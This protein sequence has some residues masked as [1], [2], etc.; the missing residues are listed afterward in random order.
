MRKIVLEKL[1]IYAIGLGIVLCSVAY[2]SYL[3]DNYTPAKWIVVY[4]TATIVLLIAIFCDLSLA[5]FRS[6]RWPLVVLLIASS[7]IAIF[8]PQVAYH[9]QILDWAAFSGIA[10]VVSG[11]CSREPRFFLKVW[12]GSVLAATFLVLV[13]GCLQLLGIDP[14]PEIFHNEFS[15]SFFGFQNMTAEFV[16]YSLLVQ[17]FVLVFMVKTKRARLCFFALLVLSVGYLGT[18]QCRAVYVALIPALAPFVYFRIRSDLRKKTVLAFVILAFAVGMPVFVPVVTQSSFLGA[19]KSAKVSNANIRIIR[20]LNT[21]QMIL[22]HPLGTGPGSYEF[23]YLPY[24]LSRKVDYEV[25]ERQ[26]ARSPHNAYLG[27]MAENGVIV[28][29]ML[30][31]IGVCFCFR[32]AK[33]GMRLK[34][35]EAI[36]VL[37]IFIFTAT[38]AVFA[39]PLENAFPFLLI[40]VSVGV[41]GSLLR[42]AEGEII[43][44]AFQRFLLTILFVACACLGSLYS[45]SKIIEINAFND[46]E[47]LEF[48]CKAFPP[49][50]RPC[51]RTAEIDI[52]KKQLVDAEVSLKRT[53]LGAPENFMALRY[54]SYVLFEQGRPKEGCQTLA[55]Y[56]SLFGNQ[57][58]LH[59]GFKEICSAF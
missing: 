17:L 12:I 44:S 28:A 40:A 33:A 51:I 16:G 32:L 18:L 35:P 45:Y 34:S 57:S 19:S 36:L 5:G 4:L 2:S 15:A 31:A 21:S 39:F 54:L 29:L 53:L 59:Q 49:N 56:D 47:K 14:L 46:L 8:R 25:T 48:A 30:I 58:S 13:Y 20:W 1:G 27:L 23:A 9:G 37:S 41:G 38:E 50:W 52:A 24:H 22:D 7:A 43:Q 11:L 10:L 55:H 6:F 42:K 3:N 26:L